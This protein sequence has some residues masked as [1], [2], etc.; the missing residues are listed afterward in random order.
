MHRQPEATQPIHV[1]DPTPQPF[2]GALARP[3]WGH[4]VWLLT[5]SRERFFDLLVQRYGDFVHYHGPFSFYLV[6]HPALVRRVLQETNGAFDKQSPL[7]DRFRRPFGDGL[8]VAEGEKWRRSRRLLQPLL[9]PTQTRSYFELMVEA[10]DAVLDRWAVLDRDSTVFDAAQEMNRLT[11]EIVGRSLFRDGFDRSRDDISRWTKVIDHY[12]SKPPLPVVRSAWFPSRLNRRFYAAL[13]QMHAFVQQMI[14]DRRAGAVGDD[15][16][17]RL[18]ETGL[19]D[20]EIRDEA[21]GMIIGGHETSSAALTWAWYELSRH[22]DVERRLHAEVDSVLG[23]DPIGVEDVERLTYTRM[24]IDE[25][26][27]LHP[28]FWFENRNV[29]KEVE[30]GGQTLPAGS[31]V[32]FSRYSL[33][34]HPAFWRQPERF[35]PERFEP[36]AEENKRSTHAY[37]PFG[38]GPRVCIGVHFALLELV[39]LLATLARR[40]RVVVD[41]SDRH[42]P[43]ALLTLRPRYGL[44]VRVVQR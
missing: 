29:A 27:R 11:L 28:P 6:N 1:P 33:H 32:A 4:K 23:D 22:P 2:E 12:S 31:T 35:D 3:P 36:G 34:R 43:Q 17:S 9:G 10:A 41:A 40:F 24:V 13:R 5:Q 25:T 38:G 19:T 26:L 7:Y 37:V 42:E 44:R 20:A 8:V 18:C 21:V 30:L 14:D 16:L 15:L 39:V